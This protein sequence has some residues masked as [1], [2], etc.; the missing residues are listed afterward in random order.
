MEPLPAEQYSSFTTDSI[1][2][3][4]DIFGIVKLPVVVH[5]LTSEK[6]RK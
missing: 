4:V 2:N 5:P 3:A 1:S 6:L